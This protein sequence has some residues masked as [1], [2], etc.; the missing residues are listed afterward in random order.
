M[1]VCLQYC[2]LQ[3]VHLYGIQSI[4]IFIYNTYSNTFLLENGRQGVFEIRVKL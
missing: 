2:T 3:H 1:T 4:Q